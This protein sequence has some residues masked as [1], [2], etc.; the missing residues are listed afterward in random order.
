MKIAI[1]TLPLLSPLTGVGYYTWKVS[2]A[3]R[4]IGPQH[5]YTYYYGYYSPHLIRPG[6]NP[7]SLYRLKELTL[8]IPLVKHVVRNMKDWANYFSTRSFDLYFEPNFVPLKISARRI[9]VTVPDFSFAH[10]PEWHTIDKVRYFKK[11]FW[12]KIGK[13][14]R[15]I[16]ISDFIK[17]EAVR[18]FWLARRSAH[19]DPLRN[20]SRSV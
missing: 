19:H 6:E 12:K 18:P 20:R 3:L 2:E 4:K 14:N 11:Q 15:I 8:K 5:E 7:E 17:N 9:V 10:F 1:D 13:A 16:V